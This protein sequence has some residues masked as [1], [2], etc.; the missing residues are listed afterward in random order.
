MTISEPAIRLFGGFTQEQL[1]DLATSAAPSI[2][3][4]TDVVF[5]IGLGQ[6]GIQSVANVQSLTLEIK[7]LANKIGAPLVSKTVS[8]F[9]D[10]T[11]QAT[12][13]SGARQHALIALTNEDTSIPAGTYWLVLSV[14]TTDDPAK[15]YTAGGAILAVV[16]DGAQGGGAAPYFTTGQ[17]DARY[18]L[19]NAAT[20]K[21]LILQN[22]SA[23]PAAPNIDMQ[24]FYDTVVQNDFGGTPWDNGAGLLT[25]PAGKYMIG[26]FF[27]MDGDVAGLGATPFRASPYAAETTEGATIMQAQRENCTDTF[28][29]TFNFQFQTGGS[30]VLQFRAMYYTAGGSGSVYHGAYN[31]LTITQI[32]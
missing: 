11:T 23:Q 32:A 17:S 25:L 3:R 2:W 9:D 27:A 21:T 6:G 13:D 29:D 10:T 7:E 16:E 1:I 19:K 4:G 20:A 15:I 28:I 5:Q 14:V 12:W 8:T 22:S 26:W 31:C 18:A 24:L 30:K